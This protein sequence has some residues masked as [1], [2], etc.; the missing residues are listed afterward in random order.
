MTKSRW[1][2]VALVVV[3]LV[4]G[5]GVVI[6]SLRPAPV[7]AL[8]HYPLELLLEEAATMSECAECHET[9]EFHRC[10]TCHDEHGSATLSGIPFYAVVAFE[11]DV[12]TPGY[13]YVNDVVPYLDHP[14]TYV[15]LRGFLLGQ[16]VEEFESVTLAS[17]DG[18][19]VTITWENLTDTAWLLPYEDGIRFAS[20]DLHVSAW[21]KGI[22][23]IV[24]VGSETPLTID[25]EPTSI[26]RLLLGPTQYLT[27]EQT[28]VMLKSAEDGEV[29]S[30]QVGSRLRGVPLTTLLDK[31]ATSSFV[32]R[33]TSGDELVFGVD[34]SQ[35]AVLVQVRGQ[36]TLAFPERARSQW[37]TDVVALESE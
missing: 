24:V 23:R 31:Q 14:A 34:E 5:V 19:F 36:V 6:G 35:G 18:G 33:T 8:T 20:E 2:V 15:S 16:G 30:A 12:P 37:V 29:R 27:V 25:G 4:G 3:L 7:R 32:V 22:R 13:V 11:G 9:A 17:D 28:Q 10:S 26:G 21:L 1:L